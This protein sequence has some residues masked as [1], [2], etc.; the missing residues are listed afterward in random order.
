[1]LG[2]RIFSHLTWD[3]EGLIEV[4]QVMIIGSDL[5]ILLRPTLAS[6]LLYVKFVLLLTTVTGLNIGSNPLLYW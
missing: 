4:H 3:V 1:M 6:L 5:N 2:T